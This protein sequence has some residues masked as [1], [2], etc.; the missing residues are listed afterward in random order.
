MTEGTAICNNDCD[1]L[2][3]SN[4]PFRRYMHC[5]HCDFEYL[6]CFLPRHPV[7]KDL[8]PPPDHRIEDHDRGMDATASKDNIAVHIAEIMKLVDQYINLTK[9]TNVPNLLT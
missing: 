5:T 9:S 7:N 6:I 3:I 4:F 2:F 8:L 1:V